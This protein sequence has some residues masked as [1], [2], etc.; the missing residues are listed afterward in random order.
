MS[1]FTGFKRISCYQW[2]FLYDILQGY[3][4]FIVDIL[5]GYFAFVN[6]MLLIVLRGL[7]V[8]DFDILFQIPSS[9]KTESLL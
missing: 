3:F 9:K 7:R 4:Y 1:L 5:W 2:I 8:F 6:D